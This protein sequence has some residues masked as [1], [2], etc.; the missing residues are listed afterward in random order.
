MWILRSNGEIGWEKVGYSPCWVEEPGLNFGNDVAR[1]QILM[2]SV[3]IVPCH[4]WWSQGDG[5]IRKNEMNG[6]KVLSGCWFL[7]RLSCFKLIPLSI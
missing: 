7:G 5:G 4:P 6:R 1:T 2:R 3:G